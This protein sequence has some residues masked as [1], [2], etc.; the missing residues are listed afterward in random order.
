MSNLPGLIN[1]LAARL[2]AL[3]GNRREAE[4]HEAEVEAQIEA[5]LL[6]SVSLTGVDVAAPERPE[7]PSKLIGSTR[8]LSENGLAIVLPSLRIGSG[9]I[10]DEGHTLRIVLDIYPAGLVEM[11]ATVAHHRPLGEKE[12]T[13]GH[14]LGLSI[15]GMSESDRARYLEYLGTLE[16]HDP[17]L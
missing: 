4:R 2:R 15:T 16:R 12:K 8:N 14:L 10:T 6:L 1:H 17:A 5:R 13:M 3:V 7:R 11:D 9:L